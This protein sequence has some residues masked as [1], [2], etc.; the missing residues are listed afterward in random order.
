MSLAS[1]T[2]LPTVIGDLA[3]RRVVEILVPLGGAK[4]M[5]IDALTTMVEQAERISPGV[6]T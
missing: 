2:R 6:A 1:S 3:G 4:V 5:V